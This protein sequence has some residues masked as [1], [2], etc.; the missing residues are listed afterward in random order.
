MRPD[1]FRGRRATTSGRP[2]TTCAAYG[3]DLRL[4]FEDDPRNVA[5]FRAEGIACVYIHSGYYDVTRRSARRAGS[6]HR[7]LGNG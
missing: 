4:A 1:D 6:Q 3:F 5:M 7:V 2:S